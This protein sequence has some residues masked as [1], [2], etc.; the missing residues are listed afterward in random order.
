LRV[1]PIEGET[2]TALGMIGGPV[3]MGLGATAMGR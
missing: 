3:G 2:E 1:R